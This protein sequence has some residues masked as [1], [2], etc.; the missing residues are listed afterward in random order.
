MSPNSFGGS[1]ESSPFVGS[2]DTVKR[3]AVRQGSEGLPSRSSVPEERY[4]PEHPAETLQD[5][6]PAR[7]VV[8]LLIAYN[9]QWTLECRPIG[10]ALESKNLC[11]GNCYLLLRS[12]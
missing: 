2:E 10:T 11:V 7:F 6:A 3:V 8:V 9:P 5:V 1:A 4:P 12:D